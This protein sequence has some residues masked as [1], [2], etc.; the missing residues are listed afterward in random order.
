MASCHEAAIIRREFGKDFIIVT[1]GIRP[2]GADVGDQKRVATPTE[3]IQ[4]GADHIVIGR[5]IWAAKN[6]RD[7][8]LKVLEELKAI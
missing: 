5:P 3:A 1:P 8:A 2:A 6:P 4:N 7:A